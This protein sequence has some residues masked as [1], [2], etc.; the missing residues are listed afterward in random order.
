MVGPPVNALDDGVGRSRQ[1]V[2]QAAG[3]QSAEHRVGRILALQCKH[4][5]V[6]LA[7]CP[8]HG[9]MHGLDD[10]AADREIAQRTLDPGFER[11]ATRRH[12]FGEAEP[13]ELGGPADH[14]PP[15]RRVF[16]WSARPK[17]GDAGALVDRITECPVEAGPALGL[18]LLFQGRTD[19]LLAARAQL[20]GDPLGG[21]IAKSPADVGAADDQV[22]AV[23]ASPADEDMDMRV[24]GIPVVD[25]DPIEPGAEIAF[26]IRHQLTGEGAQ[27]LQFS[28]VLG[29]YDEAKMMPVV[30]AALGEGLLIGGVGTGIEH[31]G[32]GA[33][34]GNAVAL[35][36]DD[37]IGQRR[38]PE[39]ASGVSNHAGLRHH[40]ARAGTERQRKRRAAPAAEARAMCPAR[41]AT[42]ALADVSGLLGGPHDLADE[43]VRPAAVAAAVTNAAEPDAEVVVTSAHGRSPVRQNGDGAERAEMLGVSLGSASRVVRR[44][45]KIPQSDQPPAPGRR[46]RF[47]LAVVRS[48]TLLPHAS[49]QNMRTHATSCEMPSFPSWRP[50]LG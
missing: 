3:H 15:Q 27:I 36:I 21:A 46:R 17:V 45:G 24:V 40:A 25:R 13:F 10:V 39:T 7:P 38:R 32:V 42:E 37:M 26:G 20:Q 1:L 22:L 33:V 23:V 28:G 50:L 4:G 48:C 47:S 41:P 12:L 43:R 35:Q 11:P 44:D 30:P 49:P 31:A 19:F 9:P 14:Q 34:M 6:R 18:D 5:H 29:R 16:T 8:C 2:M